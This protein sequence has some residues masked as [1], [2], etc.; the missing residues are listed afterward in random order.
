MRDNTFLVRRKKSINR[1]G[2]YLILI[3]LL[4]TLAGCSLS[5]NENSSGVASEP[6]VAPTAYN[7]ENPAHILILHSYHPEYLW[8]QELNTGILAGLAQGGYSEEA[9]NIVL[10]YYWMDT[11]R[12]NSDAYM[13]RIG[14]DATLYIQMT[15]PDLVIATDDNAFRLVV[16]S[17]EDESRPFVL[18]GLNG[19]LADYDLTNRPNI[20]GVLERMHFQETM[21][22]IRRVFPDAKK[23]ILLSD[24]SDTSIALIPDFLTAATQAELIATTLTAQSFAQ[25]QRYA[26]SA[27]ERGDVL[28]LGQYHTLVDEE[29]TVI[30]SREVIDWLVANSPLPVV[31][32]WEFSVQDGALGG[33]VISG[34]TQGT[35]AG[36]AAVHILNGDAPKDIGFVEPKRG[37][38]TINWAAAQRWGVTFPLDL[39]EVSQIYESGVVNR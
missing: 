27:F 25:F 6:T 21:G 18:A 17:W 9:G 30:D 13:G 23:V 39:L 1:V 37:K 33:S 22:W 4:V 12:L 15:W 20:A 26:E 36:L 35:E 7:A 16:R 34:E 38:L 10:D 19:R 8:E 11:K 32:I 3:L 28:V 14:R 2:N 29:G 31:A 24:Q 5:D